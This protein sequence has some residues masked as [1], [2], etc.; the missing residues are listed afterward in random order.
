M[1]GANQE[2]NEQAAANGAATIKARETAER[3]TAPVTRAATS[4][5]GLTDEAATAAK[6]GAA[7]AADATSG[8]AHRAVKGVEAGRRAVVTASGRVAASARTAWTSLADRKA[9]AAGVGAGLT[10]LTAVSFVAGRR[11]ERRGHGPVTRLT[12]GRI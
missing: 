3:A 12:G 7:R 1:T 8:A 10:A 6:S 11:T 9:V 5:A 2:T 4:A